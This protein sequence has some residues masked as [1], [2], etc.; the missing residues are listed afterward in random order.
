MIVCL[1]STA[2]ANRDASPRVPSPAHLV[3]GPVFEAVGQVRTSADDDIGSVYRMHR[4]RSSDRVTEFM[5]ASEIDAT[6]DLGLYRTADDKGGAVDPDLFTSGEAFPADGEVI[7]SRGAT[8]EKRLWELLG[9][10]ADPQVDY[11]VCLTRKS[12]GGAGV[13]SSRVRFTGGY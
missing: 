4:L 11:D 5:I 2:V 10:S 3:R 13:V 12:E 9:L 8:I 6:F 1:K 7:H